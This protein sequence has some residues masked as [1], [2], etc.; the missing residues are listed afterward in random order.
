MTLRGMSVSARMQQAPTCAHA[1]Y[2]RLTVALRKRHDD[3]HF[4][5]HYKARHADGRAAE[6]TRQHHVDGD[7]NATRNVPLRNLGRV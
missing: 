4:K 1:P 6:E 5:L 2:P 7:L 3:A